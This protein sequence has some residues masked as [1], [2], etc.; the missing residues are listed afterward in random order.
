MKARFLQGIALLTVI[1][2]TA[3]QSFA[4][5][6]S[7]FTTES[8]LASG[9]WVKI[10]V[11][12][13]GVHEISAQQL[14][15]MGFGDISTVKIFGHGGTVLSEVLSE[16]QPDD[17]VQIPAWATN[18][19]VIF[20]A[21]GATTVTAN[22][23]SGN[24]YH[25]IDVNPYDSHGYY[26][27]TDSDKYS[28]LNITADESTANETTETVETSYDYIVH[29][30]DVYSF[31]NSGKTFFGEDLLNEAIPSFALPGRTASTPV[32]L[33][34]SIAGNVDAASTVSATIND[35]E[36][37]LSSNKL[38]KIG[39]YHKYES[40][41]P[42]GTC[43]LLPVSDTYSLAIGIADTSINAAR[44][45]YYTV[46]YQQSNA[47]PADS[48]QMRLAFHNP[49]KS[50]SILIKGNDEAIAVWNV[51]DEAPKNMAISVAEDGSTIFTATSAE[52]WEQYVAF[53]PS[54]T[55]KQ[56]VIE[57]VIDNQN[58]HG[59]TTPDMVIIYPRN[60]EEQATRLADMHRT[61]DGFDVVI[62][63]QEQIFNEFSSGTRDAT[64][65]RLFLKMLYDRNPEKLK[66]L[67]LLGCGSFDNRQLTGAKS[68]N[69]LLTYQS[70]DSY[71]TVS[72]YTTDDY[73]GFLADNSGKSLP[74]DILSIS[75]G[76]IP[77]KTVDDAE[78]AISKTLDYIINEGSE[79][80][81]SNAL[82]ISDKGDN[83]LHTSQAEGL[84]DVI[85]EATTGSSINIEK[86]Y[87]EWYTR[88]NLNENAGGT[89]NDGRTKLAKLL[90][91]GVLYASFIG[92]A[93]PLTLTKG[94]RIWSNTDVQH[95]RYKHL[96]F[97]TVAACETA[98]FDN[99]SRSICEGLILSPEGGAIGA[100]A[101]AR[102]VYSSQNDKLNKA[103]AKILFSL[104]DNGNYR[105]I[106]EACMEAKK[107]FGTAYN[108]NKLSFTLFGDPAVRF[109]FP[110][111]RC[112]VSSING[113]STESDSI[114][115]YPLTTATL[116][117]VIN[118]AEGAIDTSFN[119]DVTVT[120]FDKAVSYKTITSPSTKIQYD[121]Y[122][123]REK[124]SMAGAKAEN[125]EFT[126]NVSIPANCIA[127]GDSCLIRIFAQSSDNRIVSGYEDRFVINSYDESVAVKDDTAPKITKLQIDGLDTG[128]KIY[129]SSNPTISF[130][131]TDD[132]GINTKPNDLQGAMTLL[133]DNGK[134][135]LPQLSN[136]VTAEDN[137]RTVTGN[138]QLHNLATGSH[139]LYISVSDI[140]GNT[141]TTECIFNVVDDNLSC[142]L[143]ATEEITSSSVDLSVS[144][145]YDLSN[146]TLHIKDNTDYPVLIKKINGTE[147]TWDLTDSEGNRVKPGRY[148]LFVS[149][150]GKDGYGVSEP[151][152][153]IVRK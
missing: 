51:T 73:F 108:Y 26:F 136:L 70:T 65:Y 125:G 130:T 45:D 15:E 138:V 96:P 151:I 34:M 38:S 58:L 13:T 3:Q 128:K 107:T 77:A 1:L 124:L 8:K 146:C 32:T 74:T 80:W 114:A 102:T 72:S 142:T 106:G 86:I 145:E 119:G 150:H 115:L 39:T 147:Y 50:Q 134:S 63:E 67:L 143:S 16:S 53:K 24:P 66:Y 37:P 131:A 52:T 90:K 30:K 113:I 55:L 88:T 117:G 100:L 19:K 21:H 98:Q 4:L 99:D 7:H 91:E 76:R 64:A 152:H 135:G 112:K 122:Y 78:A 43:D 83:D 59:N 5:S 18:G 25:T 60:F 49:S 23:S 35:I 12:E 121:S 141:V 87:Q 110:V 48:A 71:G 148:T 61:R 103:L 57:G 95:T 31:L 33:Y 92:H 41:S 118:D 28:A 84:Q 140:S 153:V 109:R 94:N 111:N 126:V 10:R 44:L 56:V 89:E 36:I 144:G 9:K 27:V 54:A 6:D 42:Y 85:E 129:T 116:K 97:F 69:Q 101:A 93:S 47:I 62:A 123:P 79:L 29:N 11:N 14:A 40:S 17:L 137:A 68:E 120:L 127:D 46:T 132:N 139:T 22:T 149:F 20:Y 82:I 81:K 105:T 75:I 133:I 104:D 2:V